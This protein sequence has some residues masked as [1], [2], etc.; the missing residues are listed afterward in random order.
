[1]LPPESPLINTFSHH[2]RQKYGEPVGKLP[3]DV[4]VVCPNREQGGC[5]FCRPASFTA[6]HLEATDHVLQQMERG[7][8]HLLHGRFKRYLAYF[9]QETCTALPI[10]QL[11]AKIQ[12]VLEDPDCLG[13]IISTRPDYVPD[14]FLKELS[15]LIGATEKECLFELGMQ[16]AHKHSLQLLNRNHTFA[17]VKD[18]LRRIKTAGPF[19][20]GVHLIF[21]IPGESE[22]NMLHSLTAACDMGIDA[23]KIHHLQV[24]RDTPL[25]EMYTRGEVELFTLEHYMAFLLRALPRIPV[26]VVI[27]RLWATSHPDLLVAPKWNILAT[28]LSEELLGRMRQQGVR[29]GTT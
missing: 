21:G 19:E 20:T 1:M 9:Q 6:G 29:Q 10:D 3:I 26:R 7:K 2:Y 23:L 12:M 11:L 18:A 16:T 22:D 27:H 5:I 14:P 4:D 17:E 24:I 25:H 15:P 8:R 13:L 28:Q